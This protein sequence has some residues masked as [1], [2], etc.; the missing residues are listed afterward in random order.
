MILVTLVAGV[1]ELNKSTSIE[2]GRSQIL[3]SIITYTNNKKINV[4][5]VVL[6]GLYCVGY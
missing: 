4:L 3:M 6:K 2:D 1:L 5:C